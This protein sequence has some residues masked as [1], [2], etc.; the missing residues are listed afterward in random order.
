MKNSNFI[1]IISISAFFA[2]SNSYAETEKECFEKTSRAIFKFNQGFDK[3][4][5]GPVS[6]AYNKLP[7]PIKSGTGNFTSNI[8]TLL[9]IPNHLLQGNVSGA[10]NAFG[11]FFINSTIGIFGLNDVASSLNIEDTGENLS[12]SLGVYG[13]NNGCYF[14]LPVLGPTTARDTFGMIGDTFMDPFSTM[15]LREREVLNTTG[16]TSDYFAVKGATAVDF[17]GKNDKNFKSLEKNSVDL[18][19]AQKSLYLQNQKRKINNSNSSEDED[20]GN[21]DK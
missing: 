13:V 11:S 5:M 14:V 4:V 18:Y 7:K 15:T 1:I 6:R 8:G 17:R 3:T 9:S 20:W 19:S 21:L 10:G 12:Q 16:Q 2:F